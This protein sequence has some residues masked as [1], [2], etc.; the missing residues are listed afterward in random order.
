MR[1]DLREVQ[2]IVKHK[3]SKN[4]KYDCLNFLIGLRLNILK[5]IDINSKIT[6]F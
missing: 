2:S 5:I 4:H 1:Q 6:S 3:D